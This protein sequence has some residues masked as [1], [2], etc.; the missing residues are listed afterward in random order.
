MAP[1]RKNKVFGDVNRNLLHNNPSLN[2]KMGQQVPPKAEN[3]IL[4]CI[5]TSPVPVAAR[6]L[7]LWVLIPPVAWMF[8]CCDCCVLQ[9]RGLC[10]G[11][12]TRPEKSYRLCRVVVCDLEASITR[13]PWST[14]KGGRA[15]RQKQTKHSH[16]TRQY[17]D[18]LLTTIRFNV[19]VSHYKIIK[20]KVTFYCFRQ[21]LL[22]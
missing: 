4:D 14:G 3:F 22:L 8:V 6:L 17:K 9:G 11:L 18:K 10:D 1:T 19:I 12:I 16:V 15:S 21:V 20:R 2:R 13:R 7:R 5:R